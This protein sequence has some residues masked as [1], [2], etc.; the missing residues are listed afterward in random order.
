[1]P[2]VDNVETVIVPPILVSTEVAARAMDLP[3][4]TFQALRKEPWMPRPVQLAPRIIRW[5][6]TELQD[7]IKHI[8][9]SDSGEPAQLQASR[10]KA[11]QPPPFGG[12][13]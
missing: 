2:Q 6:F 3:V 11:T 9:R 12:Q 1:M 8:R 13:L 4:R 5:P 10:R 7:A